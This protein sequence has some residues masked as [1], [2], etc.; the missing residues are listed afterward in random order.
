MGLF[1]DYR[2]ELEEDTVINNMNVTDMQMKLPAIKHKWTARLINHK[3]NLNKK[4]H[5]LKTARK[6]L[7]EKSMADAAIKLSKIAIGNNIEEHDTIIKIREQIREE[8]LLIEY[9]EKAEKILG[10]M[11][12]DIKNLIEL[13][14]LEQL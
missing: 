4:D 14:K 13:M 6:T 5:L 9:L 12:F 3:I 1:E 10:N 7:M 11:S 8:E 2:K